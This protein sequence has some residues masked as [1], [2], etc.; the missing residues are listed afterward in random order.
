M[1][2]PI[3]RVGDR[4]RPLAIAIS[5]LAA[6]ALSRP[7][8]FA[9]RPA[10]PSRQ[11]IRRLGR[12]IP[13]ANS[14]RFSAPPPAARL[15][16][17]PSATPAPSSTALH[18]AAIHPRCHPRRNSSANSP[19]SGY[20]AEPRHIRLLLQRPRNRLRG[21]RQSHRTETQFSPHARVQ[22]FLAST[23]G[24]LASVRPVPVDIPGG[25]QFNFTFDFQG[26]V[27]LFNSSRTRAWRIGYKY[28]AHFQRLPP[29]FQSRR[30]LPTNLHRLLLL[31]LTATAPQQNVRPPPSRKS[32]CECRILLPSNRCAPPTD[33]T[34]PRQ[35]AQAPRP[36]EKTG[37]LRPDSAGRRMS[38]RFLSQLRKPVR[39]SDHPFPQ[40]T[41][42][43]ESPPPGDPAIS[44]RDKR[45]P[46]QHP[47]QNQRP[48]R[49]R[50]RIE[51][52][53]FKFHRDA[54]L[55]GDA[56]SNC[57]RRENPRPA[58]HE[59]DR[60]PRQNAPEQHRRKL[61]RHRSHAVQRGREKILRRPP[62]RVCNSGASERSPPVRI[63]HARA[64]PAVLHQFAELDVVH[65][66]H[67]EAFVLADCDVRGCA[68]PSEMRR[69]PRKSASPAG[70]IRHGLRT[71]AKPARKMSSANFSP[72][73][74][75]SACPNSGR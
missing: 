57:H 36:A 68:A 17:S 40:I 33:P 66:F 27:D 67:C 51:W 6:L 4:S 74:Y 5:L 10:L 41:Q 75:V 2:K 61:R 48:R 21:R 73:V 26:G 1:P 37:P 69:C 32:R 14:P 15:A 43:V 46:D 60:H 7:R 22:P 63:R 30:R 9:I 70:P 55:H 65:H 23:A 11:R 34:H 62:Y 20:V 45:R 3:F 8:C 58:M 24:F 49:D 44:Q 64:E 18:R 28:A 47:A 19:T 38:V 54:S 35:L 13:S 12:A 39:P 42:P 52:R 59:R 25:T 16:S 29:R 53:H 31:P 56:Q 71:I 72:N 50:Q